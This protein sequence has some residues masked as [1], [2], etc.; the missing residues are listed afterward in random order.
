M[1][2]T[3]VR[4][5]QQSSA[6]AHAAWLVSLA[7][8]HSRQVQA[9]TGWCSHACMPAAHCLRVRAD[10]CRIVQCLL[11]PESTCLLLPDSA[12]LL[13]PES[14]CL[15]LPESAYILFPESACLL[16]A[17]SVSPESACSLLPEK[18][19]AYC[20]LRRVRLWWVMVWWALRRCRSWA[21]RL[22]SP[23]RPTS[24]VCHPTQRRCSSRPSSP[25]P[26]ISRVRLFTT[27]SKGPA[28][29]CALVHVYL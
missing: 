16:Y 11:L 24:S 10:C 26:W 18:C 22:F 8:C 17:G 5:N 12:C 15:L 23:C 27:A 4:V 13:L 20:C 6:S 21:R 29:E 19:S 28:V 7:H 2:I 14:A 3:D 9:A 1:L 25:L